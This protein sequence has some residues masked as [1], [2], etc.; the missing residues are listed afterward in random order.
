M[1]PKEK[2][3]DLFVT[4]FELIDDIYSTEAAKEIAKKY[5]LIAVDR[6]LN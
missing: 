3:Q 1:T 5:A 4:Y 2:A 6:F